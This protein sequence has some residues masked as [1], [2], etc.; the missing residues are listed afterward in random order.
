MLILK[1]DRG[2]FLARDFPAQSMDAHSMNGLS[3]AATFDV[4]RV[5]TA[6]CMSGLCTIGGVKECVCYGSLFAALQ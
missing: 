3:F 5:A 4:F 1:I 6:R 2:I